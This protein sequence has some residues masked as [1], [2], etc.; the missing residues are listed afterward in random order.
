MAESRKINPQY[1]FKGLLNDHIPIYGTEKTLEIGYNVDDHIDA[2][3]L[4]ADKGIPG[5]I[6]VLGNNE[7]TNIDVV[8]KICQHLD[9]YIPQKNSYKNL[10][11]FVLD[12]PDTI[13]DMQLTHH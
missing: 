9:E 6:I 8:N 7:K 3:L 10:I 1:Y 13:L 5:K 11:K 12:R 2:I 4:V